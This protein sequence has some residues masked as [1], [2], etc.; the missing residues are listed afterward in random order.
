[1]EPKNAIKEDP[2]AEFSNPDRAIFRNVFDF[3]GTLDTEGRVL[4]LEGTIFERTNTN[5]KLL[6]D[7]MFAETVF[8]Q[9][10]ENTPKLLEKAIDDAAGGQ[11]SK[12]I[13]DFRVSADEKLA[14]E[15]LVQP[16]DE[17]GGDRTLF[18]CG[19]SFEE[20][21]GR[22][23]QSSGASEQLLFAAENA[24]IGLWFWDFRENRI[25]ATP[26]CN[27]LFGLP[28]YESFTYAAYRRAIHP[29]D[30][31]FVDNFLGASRT[32]GTKYKEEFRVLYSDGSVEWIS[33]EGRSFLDEN[34]AP[35]RMMGVVQKITEQKIAADE[36]VRVHEK[37]RRSREEAVEANR[38]K[39]FFLAFVSHELRSPLNAILGWARLLLTRDLDEN[40]SKTAVETIEKSAKFQ[41]KLINDLV[42]SHR[43]ASGRIRL[44]YQPT[45]LYDIVR[46]SFQA[47][48][49]LAEAKNIDYRFNSDTERIPLFG[50][51]NRL[52]QVFGNLLSN[53]LKFTPEGGRVA[54][55]IHTGPESVQVHV[56]DNGQGIEPTELPHIFKHYSQ[57]DVERVKMTHSLGLGLSIV[58]ILVSKHGGV[59]HAESEGTGK[60]SRFTVTLPLTEAGVELHENEVPRSMLYDKPLEGHSIV[61]VE[62][63]ADSREVLEL[64]LKQNGASVRSFDSVRAVL[65][66]WS[67]SPSP[68]LLISDLGMPDEDGFS[69]IQ[70][71]RG[72]APEEGGKIPAIALSAF[73]SEES[74]R[75][76]LE[77]GFDRYRTKPFE[78]DLLIQDLMDLLGQHRTADSE[79]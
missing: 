78:H 4:R 41:L 23:G 24:A 29:E 30:R 43:V 55:H 51:S 59:V 35:S 67:S 10:S 17:N 27:E 65:A 40:Q 8:W 47:Q 50:D 2:S 3:F 1:M 5:P 13:L 36:L 46:N 64:F 54:M 22:L 21:V 69:L 26:R 34:D 16:L 76:A 12:V 58:K 70:K 73:T 49:P 14:M 53:A 18:I 68:H 38:S 39:D 11:N 6:S 71:I 56:I 44:E 52:Q 42:D 74:R 7:Q 9:S 37:E 33:A 31:E 63:D 45:N 28:A 48:K 77:L 57:G 20:S 25:Y 61:I 79:S 60:G 19:R 15:V 72:F 62:D 75:R 32:E 66:D